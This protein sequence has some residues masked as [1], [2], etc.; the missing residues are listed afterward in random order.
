MA[1]GNKPARY[2][3]EERCTEEARQHKTRSDFHKSSG[4]AYN[5]AKRYEI[6]ELICGHMELGKSR[7][8][9]WSFELPFLS[10]EEIFGAAAKHKTISDFAILNPVVFAEAES[11]NW[12][13]EACKHMK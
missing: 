4:G 2:W 5:A 7:S 13:E 6:L 11:N 1:K 9:D 3:T 8:S 10:K 12:L